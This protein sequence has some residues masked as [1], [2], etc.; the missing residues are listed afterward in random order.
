MKSK[1]LQKL[2][3]VWYKRLSESGFEDIEDEK[4][5]L[6][7]WSTHN[8]KASSSLQKKAKAEYYRLAGQYLYDKDFSLFKDGSYRIAWMLHCEGLSHKEIGALMMLSEDKIRY[9]IRKM[10]TLFFKSG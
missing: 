3:A 9:R 5:N 8:D 2:Q 10:R 6:K 1:Q 7:S 4:G